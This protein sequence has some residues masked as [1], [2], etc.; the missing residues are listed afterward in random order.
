MTIFTLIGIAIVVGFL[1]WLGEVIFR[2][3]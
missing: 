3:Y 2:N 1:Y